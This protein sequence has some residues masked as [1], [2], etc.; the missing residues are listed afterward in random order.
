[1]ARGAEIHG[2]RGARGEGGGEVAADAHAEGP[3]AGGGA[4]VLAVERRIRAVDG[5]G[6]FQAG[7]GAGGE[8][9]GD[10]LA[11]AAGCAQQED[12]F[13]CAHGY[14]TSPH[15]RRVAR[16]FSLFSGAMSHRGRR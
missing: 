3:D 2:D 5:G 13:R 15:C 8:Q 4:G 14:F 7:D 12:F 6:E 11:H 9:A 16:S 10:G 1:M